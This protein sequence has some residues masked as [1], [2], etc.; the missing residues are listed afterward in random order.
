MLTAWGWQFT[1][2]LLDPKSEDEVHVEVQYG[3]AQP[4]AA[5]VPH[6][7]VAA[8]WTPPSLLANLYVL[9]QLRDNWSTIEA[10]TRLNVLDALTT[11]LAKFL[12][13]FSS[14]SS[15]AGLT[16]PADGAPRSDTFDIEVSVAGTKPTTLRVMQTIMAP[17][18]IPVSAGLGTAIVYALADGFNNTATLVGSS[19]LRSF[20]VVL[21][22]TR[23]EQLYR[24]APSTNAVLVYSC[25]PVQSPVDYH[26]LN[27]WGSE[28]Q[29]L[30]Y[31]VAGRPLKDAL[32]AFF[33]ALFNKTDLS[34]MG[35]EIDVSLVWRKGSLDITTPFS[36]LP[37]DFLLADKTFAGAAQYVVDVCSQLP[38]P[39]LPAPPDVENGSAGVRLRIKITDQPPTAAGAQLPQAPPARTLLDIAAIDFKLS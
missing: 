37:S 20:K 31:D 4:A 38:N 18:A 36:I 1:F 23:N 13:G 8:S 26:P 39:A 24:N 10:R 15:P 33:Q 12:G 29:P 27:E 21:T 35:V 5:E 9:K 19:P 17:N 14:T 3:S 7:L 30:A 34:T 16:M 11:S 25:A 2:G 6:S 32:I 28:T 22:R